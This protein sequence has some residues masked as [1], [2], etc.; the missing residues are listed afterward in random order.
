MREISRDSDSYRF[1]MSQPD[2][3]VYLF[4]EA[5]EDVNEVCCRTW[6]MTR[7]ELIGRSPLEFSPELQSDGSRSDVVGRQRF[8]SAFEGHTQWFRWLYLKGG[9]QASEALCHLE[10]IRVDGRR[11][12]LV[13][14]RDLPATANRLAR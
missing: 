11:R 8:E 12:L 9:E 6:G 1:M 5:I 14:W 7:E 10:C 3:G 13:R 2:E 4:G